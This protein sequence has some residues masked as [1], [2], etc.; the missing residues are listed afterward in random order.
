MKDTL[1]AELHR[2]IGL[3]S[4]GQV[5]SPLIHLISEYARCFWMFASDTEDPPHHPTHLFLYDPFTRQIVHDQDLAKGEIWVPNCWSMFTRSNNRSLFLW[6]IV[7]SRDAQIFQ[8]QYD[9]KKLYR[10]QK[11]FKMTISETPMTVIVRGRDNIL[12]FVCTGHSLYVRTLLYKWKRFD[13]QTEKWDVATTMVSDYDDYNSTYVIISHS[14]GATSIG[15]K[16][17]VAIEGININRK[18]HCPSMQQ[19]RCFAYDGDT[20]VQPII[21]PISSQIS[22]PMIVARPCSIGHVR[23]RELKQQVSKQQALKE[24]SSKQQA[25]KEQELKQQDEQD[26][27]VAVFNSFMVLIKIK[28]RYPSLTFY[29]P[30]IMIWSYPGQAVTESPTPRPRQSMYFADSDL[31]CLI[32][33]ILLDINAN[34]NQSHRRKSQPSARSFQF[35]FKTRDWIECSNV[36][37]ELLSCRLITMI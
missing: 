27:V 15:P 8:I 23:Q 6:S 13:L 18:I 4:S 3:E 37:K 32:D 29:P 30:E 22:L 20:Y 19:F 31:W 11:E 21:I 26:M 17:F 25:L 24:Q 28:T 2:S 1:I 9:L 12:D 34:R 5:L 16:S 7:K 36:P 35:C 33:P 10:E 14:F